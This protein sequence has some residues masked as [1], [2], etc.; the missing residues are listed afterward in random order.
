MIKTRPQKTKTTSQL[1]KELDEVF[2]LF[3]RARDCDSLGL[4]TCFVS[5]ARVPWKQAD[6]AHYMSRKHMATRFEEYNVHACSIDS[7]RFDPDHDV[8]Y[9]TKMVLKYGRELPLQLDNMSKS[10]VKFTAAELQE[11]IEFY[12]EEV[13]KLRALKNI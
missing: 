11:K 7:N 4:I 10:M 13:K 6:A 12:K 1:I 2:S 5:G 9:H 8:K 3:V